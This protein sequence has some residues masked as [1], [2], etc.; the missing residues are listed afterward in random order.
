[1]QDEAAP[2]YPALDFI[3]RKNLTPMVSLRGLAQ[4]R[5]FGADMEGM[6]M[7]ETALMKLD[8]ARQAL[9]EARTLADVKKIQGMAE[10]ARILCKTAR[11]SRE[12]MNQAAEIALLAARKAG[13]ILKQLE[14]NPGPGRGNKTSASVAVLSEYRQTLRDTATAE[15]TAQHWQ[16]LAAIPDPVAQEYIATVRKAGSGEITAAGLMREFVH[17][18]RA[19]MAVKPIPIPEGTYRVVYADPPWDYGNPIAEGYGPAENH[20]ATMKLDELCAMPLPKIADNAV[21]FL[22]ATAPFLVKAL[23]V[24][25]AWGFEYKTHFVW[26]KVRHNFGH[27]SSVRHEDLLVATRGSCLPDSK[28][29]VDSVQSIERTEHSRK[30]AEFR[31]IIDRLYTHGRRVELFARGA[32]PAGWDGFGN[33]FAPA[34]VAEDFAA[35]MAA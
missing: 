20:Y 9:T 8:K 4:Q 5:T 19:A 23:K 21:L 34:D 2:I 30:P 29:L 12:I 24:V 15:R 3:S 17:Q 35:E 33:E 16:K 18:T 10:A 13:E 25:P 28:E 22:W 6:T 31:A 26:D 27:Y 14:R 1:M 11:V 7:S 32:L